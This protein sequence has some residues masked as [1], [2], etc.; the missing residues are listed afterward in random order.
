MPRDV[1]NPSDILPENSSHQH[2]DMHRKQ[3]IDAYVTA[4][5]AQKEAKKQG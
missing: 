5:E 4:V 1:P 2:K 3:G